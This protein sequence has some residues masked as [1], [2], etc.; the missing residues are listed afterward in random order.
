[1]YKRQPYEPADNLFDSL[2]RSLAEFAQLYDPYDFADQYEDFQDAVQNQKD[3]LNDIAGLE[4]YIKFMNAIIMEEN[5]NDTFVTAK[6]LREELSIYLALQK[7]SNL[8]NDNEIRYSYR[9]YISQEEP[10][11]NTGDFVFIIHNQIPVYGTIELIDEDVI[12]INLYDDN[13]L[14]ISKEDFENDLRHDYRNGY[15]YDQSRPLMRVN[16]EQ[17]QGIIV[18]DEKERNTLGYQNYVLFKRIAPLIIN[19]QAIEMIFRSPNELSVISITLNDDTVTI[20][21][22][23]NEKYL[24][25]L[26]LSLIH[27]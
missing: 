5:N 9:A 13:D 10:R 11:Y 17:E 23:G 21:H 3:T 15:L 26:D 27:I 14:E 2:A 19:N 16:D 8:S 6:M 18:A 20:D 4:G 1:M 12:I 22:N 24:F 7:G 25:Q